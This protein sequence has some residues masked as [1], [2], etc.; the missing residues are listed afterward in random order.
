MGTIHV[1]R[2]EFY[3]L[4]A[5]RL[6]PIKRAEAIVLE[7]DVSDSSRAIAAT[8]KYAQYPEGTPGLETRLT[9]EL[10][11]RVE[12]CHVISSIQRR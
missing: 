12:S 10:R 6:S 4:P 5:S 2:P 9:P 8:Q 1:G 11:Q 3:P 7:A